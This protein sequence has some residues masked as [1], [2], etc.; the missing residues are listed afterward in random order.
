MV[1]AIGLASSFASGSLNEKQSLRVLFRQMD[2]QLMGLDQNS[3]G[4]QSAQ[5]IQECRGLAQ[6]FSENGPVTIHGH[7]KNIQLKDGNQ[8]ILRIER[9]SE[10]YEYTGSKTAKK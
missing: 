9:V 2:E 1:A 10:W 6:T 8:A 3:T 5:A 7:V 4:A